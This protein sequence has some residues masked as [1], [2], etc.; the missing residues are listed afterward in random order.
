MKLDVGPVAPASAVAWIEW[1]EDLFGEFRAEL[2][3]EVTPSADE[4]DDVGQYLEQCM[5]RTR[6][7]ETF[8]WQ[9]EVDPGQA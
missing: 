6:A 7:I 1:A 4:M 3:S 8:R 5:A 9:G 2:T